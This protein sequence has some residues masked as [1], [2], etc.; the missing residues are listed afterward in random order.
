M[1]YL[2]KSWFKNMWKL[3]NEKVKEEPI[4]RFKNIDL[5]IFNHEENEAE[6]ELFTLSEDIIYQAEFHAGSSEGDKFDNSVKTAERIKEYAEQKVIEELER[7]KYNLQMT[8]RPATYEYVIKR[9]KELK[10]KI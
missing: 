9:I 5:N 6:E 1:G 10:Q 2:R 4:N 3:K 7:I 8:G